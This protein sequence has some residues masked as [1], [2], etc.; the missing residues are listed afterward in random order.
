[1]KLYLD[2][3]RLPPQGFKLVRT[4]NNLKNFVRKYGE[5]IEVLD[6]DFDMGKNSVDGGNGIDFL[7]W[8]E[9]EVFTGKISLNKNLKIKCHSSSAEKRTEMEE[10]AR[11]ITAFLRSKR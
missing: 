10:I 4:V 6:L 9:E 5:Q 8:L 11:G 2:D 7:K 3:I 1:M